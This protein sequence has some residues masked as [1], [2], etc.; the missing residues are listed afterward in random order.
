MLSEISLA[1]PGLR[2]SIEIGVGNGQSCIRDLARSGELLH[3]AGIIQ[4]ERS[5]QQALGA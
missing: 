2:H 3:N 4:A 5:E 1:D